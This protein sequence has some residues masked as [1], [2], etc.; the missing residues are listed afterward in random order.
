MMKYLAVASLL[1][2]SPFAATSSRA[3]AQ[4]ARDAHGGA[5]RPQESVPAQGVDARIA[6]LE[7]ELAAEKKRHD[8]TRALLE[9]TL[10]YLDKQSKAAGVL[11]GVLDQSEQQGFAVGENWA[12]RK[13]LL[14]GLR[15]YWSEEQAGPPRLPAPAQPKA[16]APVRT[17]PQ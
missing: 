7:S 4:D 9:Q 5:Q 11:L 2:L 13:T 3:P 1:I 14:A 8:E 17:R 15:A 10:A 6:A 12:S 16:A